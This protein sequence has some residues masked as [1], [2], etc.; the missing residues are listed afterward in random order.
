MTM[1]RWLAEAF[2]AGSKSFSLIILALAF[3]G[4]APGSANAAQSLV[5][6]P[7]LAEV[8]KSDIDLWGEAALREPNGASY[9]FFETLLPPPRYV[10][11]DFRFYPLV[12]SAPNARI[13]ARL[14]SNGSGVNLHGG[15]RSWNDPGTAVTFRVGP[16]EFRFGELLDRL[17][18]PML[19]AGYLPIPSISY[20]HGLDTYCVEAFASTD[21]DLAA[22]GAVFVN[23]FLAQGTNGLVTIEMEQKPVTFSA[24]RVV[25]ESNRTL[26]Q[27]DA[28]WTWDRQRAH[29]KIGTKRAATLVIFTQP[30]P[31]MSQAQAAPKAGGSTYDYEEQRQKTRDTW[32]RILAGGMNVEIPEPRV[33]GAWKNLIIQNFSLIHGDAIRYSA[34]NQ[35]DALYETEGSDAAIALMLWGYEADTRRLLVPLLDFRREAIKFNQ[36]GHK[37]EDVA[38]YYWQTRDRAS[39]QALKPKWQR[40]VDL[41]LAS[42]GEHGLVPR[43]HYCNDIPTPV[44]SLNS[45][46]KCWRG[47]RD[48]SAALADAGE[49]AEADHL[50]KIAGR[51]RQD[52]FA[53]VEK[54][55]VTNTKPAFIPIALFGEEGPYAPL[56]ATRMGSYWNL[57]ANF[58]L[59]FEVLGPGSEYE[60]SM[61]QY[62]QQRGGLCMGMERSHP[63]PTFWTATQGVNPLYGMRYVLTLLRRDEPDRA[64]VSFYGMLAQGFTR[65]TFV[66][67]EGSTLTPLDDY[68][69]QFYCPPNSAGN[70]HFLQMLRGLL[71]QDLDL[72]DDGR[73][74]TLRLLFATPKV[75]LEEGNTLK[76]ERAPTAFGP[77][78][79]RMESKL[80]EGEVVAEVQLPQRN[81]PKRVLL[82][83][84]L[85][86]G[87]K[88]LSAVANLRELNVDER[89]TA[90][91]SALKGRVTVHFKVTKL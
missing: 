38:Q 71:V 53:A 46:A 81:E 34:G 15:A 51:L 10:N 70:G 72:D 5:S 41:I 89:G 25:G 68:G 35:Y 48:L 1:L 62:I 59:G 85:P 32:E 54:S 23:F 75:W 86:G 44:F 91:I 28:N 69:R 11:A 88:V 63:Q 12:L 61:L 24:S 30:A 45:N 43:E 90:D 56:C 36:A 33:N 87:W 47:L 29:A 57:M 79:I 52:I 77:V 19:A 8:L 17:E 2:C 37:L 67:G 26:V 66:A 6:R 84:R 82:R 80:A 27:L 65:N 49:S 39:L 7:A 20:R 31:A 18:H 58:I 40:E 76:V 16:D 9:Q 50:A 14:I 21:P 13:K 3:T 55:V 42:L 74:E 64:L 83:A 73:P 4:L 60:T 78:S 22:Q